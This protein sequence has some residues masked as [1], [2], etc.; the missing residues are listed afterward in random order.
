MQLK[1]Y[2]RLFIRSP[3]GIGGSF[4]SLGL[5]LAGIVL[6]FSVPLALLAGSAVFVSAGFLATSTTWGSKQLVDVREH[7]LLKATAQRLDMSESLRK[8]LASMRIGNMRVA[9]AVNLVVVASG[10]CL[11]AC[12]RESTYDPLAHEALE[13]SLEV[14]KLYLAE[15]DE[16]SMEKRFNID[17]AEPFGDAEA[18]SIAL[19]KEHA[20]T[21]RERRIQVEGGLHARDRMA[22]REELK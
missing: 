22:I 3:L 18:R 12:R 5:S 4:A 20:S 21:F 14:V 19:L 15:S 1:D 10:D 2:F 13:A 11:S 17:D 9:E 7:A 8:R 16:A 6:G